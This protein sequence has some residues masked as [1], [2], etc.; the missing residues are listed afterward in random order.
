[1]KIESFIKYFKRG[2]EIFK[3]VMKFLQYFKGKY[4]IVH[5]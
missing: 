5:L 3:N 1:M 2:L 4:F